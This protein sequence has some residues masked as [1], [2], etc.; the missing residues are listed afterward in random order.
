MSTRSEYSIRQLTHALE[1]VR[2]RGLRTLGVKAAAETPAI[3]AT[4]DAL[5]TDAA[6]LRA[7]LGW[8]TARDGGD[9]NS[10]TTSPPDGAFVA[11]AVGMLR[12][13]AA[14]EGGVAALRAVGAR[15]AVASAIEDGAGNGKR[16]GALRA[17]L[18]AITSGASS[19][20]EGSA[21]E[22]SFVPLEFTQVPAAASEPPPSRS[23][24]RAPDA[25]SAWEAEQAVS[26][27]TSEIDETVSAAEGWRFGVVHLCQRDQQQL[28]ELQMAMRMSV[29]NL[30]L[31]AGGVAEWV[32]AQKSAVRIGPERR[33]R[34][35]TAMV[36]L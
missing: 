24:E 1:S 21:D 3:D 18:G 10:E 7:M 15:A 16:D 36:R 4:L 11:L 8:A 9:E 23:V 12:R 28:F 22:A 13:C 32:A 25:P 20:A 31:R 14:R 26:A 17:L 19:S 34:R 35:S 6:A 33:W 2:R 29:E 27:P 5:A 30:A